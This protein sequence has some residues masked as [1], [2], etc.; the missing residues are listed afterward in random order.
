MQCQGSHKLRFHQFT[1]RLRHLPDKF[2]RMEHQ[3]KKVYLHGIQSL[4]LLI[5]AEDLSVYSGYKQVIL[6]VNAIM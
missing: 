1:C 4:S 6:W 3:V 2:A 5:S